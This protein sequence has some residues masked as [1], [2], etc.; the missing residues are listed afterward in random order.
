MSRYGQAGVRS[1]VLNIRRLFLDAAAPLCRN[2]RA[3]RRCQH[4]LVCNLYAA[5]H[6]HLWLVV[7]PLF[8]CMEARSV[9]SFR[10]D[11][12]LSGGNGLG[13][14]CVLVQMEMLGS[15]WAGKSITVLS[16]LAILLERYLETS[17]Y[18]ATCQIE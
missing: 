7:E 6:G 4:N 16:W 9:P 5:W 2:W 15:S 14:Y 8:L 11:D 18:R 12:V 3:C 17:L 1:T 10:Q 13:R